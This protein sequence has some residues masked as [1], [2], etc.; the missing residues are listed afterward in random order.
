MAF[1]S[2]M[3]VLERKQ[4]SCYEVLIIYLLVHLVLM[5]LYIHLCI[6][7]S[8]L[9]EAACDN[10]IYSL[11]SRACDKNAYRGGQ[12]HCF[13]PSVPTNLFSLTDRLG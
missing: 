11:K 1:L 9:H 8:N 4:R 5:F 2:A 7:E 12:V 10:D 3:L 13:L 6:K